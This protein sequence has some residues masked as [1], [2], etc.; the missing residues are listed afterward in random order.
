MIAAL[1]LLIFGTTFSVI[2]KNDIKVPKTT[3]FWKWL[4]YDKIVLI[5]NKRI[6]MNKIFFSTTIFLIFSLLA[7]ADEGLISIKSTYD[8]KTTAN[9]LEKSLKDKGVTVFKRIDHEKGA[10]KIGVKLRPTELIIFGNPKLGT[11]LMQCNQKTAI[12]LPQKA[13]IFE[14]ENGQVWFSYNDPKYLAAR[15]AL[16]GCNKVIA[17]MQKVLANFATIATAE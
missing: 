5:K 11:P 1:Y 17:K 8:V 13:L 4:L 6:H 12:D 14:D 7:I 16:K 15:H 9:R 2:F 10:Q 3:F